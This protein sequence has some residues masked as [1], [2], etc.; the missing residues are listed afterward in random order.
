[1]KLNIQ[2]IED[3]LYS[4]QENAKL[5]AFLSPQEVERLDAI[6]LEVLKKIAPPSS[7]QEFNSWSTKVNQAM[8]AELKEP[9]DYFGITDLAYRLDILGFLR[10]YYDSQNAQ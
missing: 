3:L 10:K 4:I 6:F 8:I 1:M 5:M 9:E 7:A 2:M